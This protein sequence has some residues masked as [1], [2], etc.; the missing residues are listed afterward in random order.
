MVVYTHNKLNTNKITHRRKTQLTNTNTNTNTNTQKKGCLTLINAE[1]DKTGLQ[2]KNIH[3]EWIDV[4]PMDNCF[5]VNIGDMLHL[6]TNGMLPCF[7]LFVVCVCV[8]VMVCLWFAKRNKKKHL[9][10]N[11]TNRK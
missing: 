10:K 1:R 8:C 11:V 6:W 7:L 4:Q 3:G 9:S 2:V 5:T